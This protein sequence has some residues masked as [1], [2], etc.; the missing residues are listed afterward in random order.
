MLTGPSPDLSPSSS[1]NSQGCMFVVGFAD[2]GAMAEP[3]SVIERKSD[4]HPDPNAI[5]LFCPF[6]KIERQSRMLIYKQY[7]LPN[8]QSI[9]ASNLLHLKRQHLLRKEEYYIPSGSFSEP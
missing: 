7:L 9:F 5:S 2:P 4:L 6:L 1:V 8:H 3:D